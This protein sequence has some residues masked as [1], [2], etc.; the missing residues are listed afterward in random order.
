[1]VKLL[2][3]LLLNI[4]LSNNISACGT[5]SACGS[6][7]KKRLVGWSRTQIKKTRQI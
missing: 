6:T 2:N 7:S 5:I 1:V 4:L 3:K